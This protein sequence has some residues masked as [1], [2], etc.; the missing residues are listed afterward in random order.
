MTAIIEAQ[1]L[2]V[3]YGHAVVVH[4]VDLEVHPGEIVALLGPNGAGKTTTLLALAGELKPFSG[5]VL[6]E[7]RESGAPL[8]RLAREGLALVTEERSVTTRLS[9]RQNLAIGRGIDVERALALFPELQPLLGR[10]G[11]LLS[12]GEQ[13]M[14]TLGR[15]LARPTELL[16]ADELSLGL[17]PL[18]VERLLRAV[19]T[20]ADSGLGALLVEQHVHRVLEIADRVYVLGQGRVQL[21]MTAAE[22]RLRL[23]EIQEHYL[24]DIPV[25]VVPAGSGAGSDQ[26][27]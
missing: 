8:H 24:T 27:G 17:A 4:E 7:G 23:K 20:A 2:T 25:G 15:A 13:Q 22:A 3:G 26:S 12:G 19:R 6:W 10:R 18:A 14:L 16:M 9:T 11:G 1:K 5:A 21:A